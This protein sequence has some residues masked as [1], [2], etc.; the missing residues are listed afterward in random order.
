MMIP[1]AGPVLVSLS[2][3]TKLSHMIDDLLGGLV[4][5]PECHLWRRCAVRD[6][7][8]VFLGTLS[9]IEI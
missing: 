7:Q 3:V 8:Y 6:K 2:I 1:V 5:Y 9:V 4:L